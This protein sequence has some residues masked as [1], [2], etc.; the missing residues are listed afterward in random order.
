MAQT[1]RQSTTVRGMRGTDCSEVWGSPHS[2]QQ[3][4]VVPCR[5]L[6]GQAC[7]QWMVL[8][9]GESRR[10]GR[11]R[12]PAKGVRELLAPTRPC[13]CGLLLHSMHPCEPL[14]GFPEDLKGRLCSHCLST[15][16]QGSPLGGA[17][18]LPHLGPASLG[19]RLPL[20]MGVALFFSVRILVCF[21]RAS[22]QFWELT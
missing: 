6:P 17:R 13:A 8:G 7:S 15:F 12:V 19:S 11:V 4:S 18:L 3:P 14:P 21:S 1:S 16:P 22:R 10:P 20:Q 9:L 5:F 2:A